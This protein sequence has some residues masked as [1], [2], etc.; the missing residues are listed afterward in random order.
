MSAGDVEWTGVDLTFTME[1]FHALPPTY[2]ARSISPSFSMLSVSLWC[3]GLKNLNELK[4]FLQMKLHME[5][6]YVK[7]IK[8]E[9]L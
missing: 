4:S 1:T 8:T 7:Q 6:Q 2:H 5:A 3:Y 9:L